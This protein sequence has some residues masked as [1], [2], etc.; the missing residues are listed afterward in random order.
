MIP[1]WATELEAAEQSLER[2]RMTA[3]QPSGSPTVRA[4]TLSFQVFLY[5][6]LDH[7]LLDCSKQLLGLPEGQTDILQSVLFALQAGDLLHVLTRF[8]FRDEVDEEFHPPIL[9][10]KS[11]FLSPRAY[12]RSLRLMARQSIRSGRRSL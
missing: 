8:G 7:S 2:H 12:C 3:F 6:L 10:Q 4:T 1:A 9:S 11:H 5:L